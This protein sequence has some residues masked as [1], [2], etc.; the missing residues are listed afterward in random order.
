MTKKKQ[1][2]VAIVG[3]GYVGLP[4]AIALSKHFK[5]IGFDKEQDRID[6]IKNNNVKTSLER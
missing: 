1:I 2:I 4:L 6:Q 3:L 5:I